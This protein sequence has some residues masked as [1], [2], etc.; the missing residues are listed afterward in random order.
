MRALATWSGA[1]AG[2]MLTLVGSLI[3]A[4]MLW[5]GVPLEVLPLPSTWQVPALLICALVCGPRAGVI[6]SVAYLTIGLVDL[7]VFH[8]GGGPGYLLNPGFGY[9]AGFVPAAWLCGRLSQQEGMNDLARLTLAAIAGLVMIQICGLLNLLVGGLLGRWA[10]PLPELLF[11]YG[12]G[13]LPSQLALCVASALL[14]LPLRRL[15][16]IE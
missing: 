12:V 11:S 9:L 2:L 6:A 15:L 10:D 7:P 4:A 8:D 5:P 14:A 16:L 13:P 3:P 1:F